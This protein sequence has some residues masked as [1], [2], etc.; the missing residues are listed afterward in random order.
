[1]LK[2]IGLLL[3][4]WAIVLFSSLIDK[5]TF[6]DLSSGEPCLLEKYC[7]N[8]KLKNYY[9]QLNISKKYIYYFAR[10]LVCIIILFPFN[11]LLSLRSFFKFNFLQPDL[12]DEILNCRLLSPI[13]SR[14]FNKGGDSSNPSNKDFRL[15]C[16]KFLRIWGM[17]FG[18]GIGETL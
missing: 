4:N 1:M 16:G 9:Y 11:L 7:S 14:F 17:L 10:G 15:N 18:V 12:G 8:L 13:L 3:C 6:F 2:S 5:S